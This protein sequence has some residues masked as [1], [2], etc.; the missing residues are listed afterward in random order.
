[1]SGIGKNEASTII[2]SR[3]AKR[4]VCSALLTNF[5]RV[6]CIKGHVSSN[7]N[8]Q[9]LTHIYQ[10]EHDGNAQAPEQVECV[11][12]LGHNLL[13]PCGHARPEIHCRCPQV[14]QSLLNLMPTTFRLTAL[15][16]KLAILTSAGV[17][18]PGSLK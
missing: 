11:R 17:S 4:N 3:V 2:F 5:G 7:A 16:P 1:M 9:A 15:P 13:Q 8:A 12:R 18:I 10:A 6:I 14:V